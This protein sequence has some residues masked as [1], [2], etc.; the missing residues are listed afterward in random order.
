[1]FS[2]CRNVENVFCGFVKLLSG[3]VWWGGRVPCSVHRWGRFGAAATVQQCCC[4]IVQQYNCATVSEM[5]KLHIRPFIALNCIGIWNPAGA[6][7]WGFER[8]QCTKWCISGWCRWN[9]K[10]SR[11]I[12]NW[13]IEQQLCY[14]ITMQLPHNVKNQT[15]PVLFPHHISWTNSKFTIITWCWLW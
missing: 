4:S 13:T 10:L 5:H 8:V 9:H 2:S 11:C 6:L 7:D 3:S 12:H 15:S 14:N 1:M